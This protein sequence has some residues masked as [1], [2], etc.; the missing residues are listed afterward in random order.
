M[1]RTKHWITALLLWFAVAPVGGVWAEVA[2]DYK[3]VSQAELVAAPETFQGQKVKVVGTFLFT[4]SDFCYQ[5][6]KTTINTRDYLCF[7]LGTPSLVRLYLKKDHPQVETLMGLHKGATVE[8]VGIFD[9]VGANYNFMVVDEI[10]VTP[11]G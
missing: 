3:V 1:R 5:V 2:A 4:G 7:A 8:A 11:A 9:F 10:T 6:R